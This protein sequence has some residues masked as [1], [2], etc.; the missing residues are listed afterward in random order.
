MRFR[1]QLITVSEDGSERMHSVAELER[2]STLRLE[3]TG[4]TL[5]EG[6]QILKHLQEVVV[7]E[8]VQACM[9]EH[10]HCAICSKPLSTKGHHQIKLQTVFGNL[11]IRSHVF[12]VAPAAREIERSPSA[13]WPRSLRRARRQRDCTWRRFSRPCFLTE[14]RPNC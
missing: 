8:Q 13:P 4:L 11:Q 12:D 2:D 3:T 7:E 14:R 6:K 9:V 1:L 5:A 10:R